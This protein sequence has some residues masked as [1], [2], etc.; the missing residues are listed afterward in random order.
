MRKNRNQKRDSLATF[1]RRDADK[2]ESLRPTLATPYPEG[3]AKGSLFRLHSASLFACF[4]LRTFRTYPHHSARV[5]LGCPVL[6][7]LSPDSFVLLCYDYLSFSLGEAPARPYGTKS[8]VSVRALRSLRLTYP[9]KNLSFI[10]ILQCPP[11]RRAPLTRK[12]YHR[13]QVMGTHDY[14]FLLLQKRC[15]IGSSPKRLLQTSAPT[16][17]A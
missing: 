1:P 7:G 16:S 11:G 2:Y 14:P 10:F 13:G 12:G 9:K 5:L 17:H 4:D 3:T 15:S 6:L 8:D